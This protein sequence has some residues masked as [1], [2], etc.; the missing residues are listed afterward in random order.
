MHPYSID[1]LYAYAQLGLN[2]SAPPEQIE[3]TVANAGIYQFSTRERIRHVERFAAFF[4]ERDRLG[5]LQDSFDAI[6]K[7]YHREAMA[8]HPDRNQGDAKA[9]EELKAINAAYEI[10]EDVYK[11]ARDH[12]KR[13]AEMRRDIETEARETTEREALATGKKPQPQ[14]QPRPE[15]RAQSQ[16]PGPIKYMA[17][18]IPRFIR[19]A[20][21]FYLGRDAIIGSRMVGSPGMVYDVIMLSQ[22]EFMRARLRLSME[23]YGIQ[24]LT[25]SKLT[26]PYIPMDVKEITVPPEEADPETFA[27]MYFWKEYGI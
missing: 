21:L 8:L 3:E 1:I 23:G 22:R 26:P 18:S 2:A 7:A 12:F 27:K 6:R 17:A 11:E 20:R 19:N 16:P 14:T 25:M 15:P 9:E 5:S 24:E 4:V 10:I 13:S